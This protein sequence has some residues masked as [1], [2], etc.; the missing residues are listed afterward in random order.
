MVAFLISLFRPK[1]VKTV[2]A[3]P[4]GSQYGVHGNETLLEAALKRV[5]HSCTVLFGARTKADFYAINQI[6]SI[7]KGWRGSFNFVPILTHE[8]EES[9]WEGARGLATSFTP[10]ALLEKEPSPDTEFYTRGPPGMIDSAI[11]IAV[12]QG[13]TLDHIHYDKFTDQST[14]TPK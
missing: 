5:E 4:F 12:N 8:P 3:Q 6:Q 9:D 14:L 2:T 7:S 10:Q 13:I 1:G 11:E